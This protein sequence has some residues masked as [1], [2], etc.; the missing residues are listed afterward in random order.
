MTTNI[1]VL[2]LEG[3]RYYIGK[4]DNVPQRFQQHLHGQGSAWTKKYKPVSLEKT[5]KHASAFEEDKV[6]KEYMAKY[7]VDKVRGGSYVQM[8]L[9][10]EQKTMLE[11]ELRGAKDLCTRCGRAGHFVKDCYAKNDANGK[12]LD[13]SSSSSSSSSSSDSSDS[14][15]KTVKT[16][17]Q[18]VSLLKQVVKEVSKPQKKTAKPK[19]AA[20]ACY[21]CGNTGHYAPDCYASR[22]A[23]GSYLD[24]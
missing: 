16:N 15:D 20:N 17:A 22:H 8:D 12:S 19:K 11:R 24:D 3:G 14:D 4:T 6:T 1:Y 13:D 23:N 7:G 10:E 5:I 21:R 9:S 18:L 2:R